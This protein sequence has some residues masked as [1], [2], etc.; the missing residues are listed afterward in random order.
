MPE[1]RNAV[2]RATAP[3]RRTTVARRSV[4][5][6]IV[7]GAQ[8]SGTTYLANLMA[9]Q[10]GFY[11]PPIKEIH[12]FNLHWAKGADWYASHFQLRSSGALQ[13]DASPSYMIHPAVPDRINEVCPE[14]KVVFVLRDPVS[15]A[16]SH[17]QH[18]KRAGWEPL[19]F[20]EALAAEDGRIS[21]DVGALE[22]DPN[23][24]G[25][26]YALYSYRTR[27]LYHRFLERFYDVLGADKILVLD[28]KKVFGGDAEEFALLGEFVGRPVPPEAGVGQRTNAG[29]Y[30]PEAGATSDATRAELRE[31][32]APHDAQLVALTGRRFS[33]MPPTD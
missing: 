33:W 29:T 4:A 3:L 14:A 13:V 11:S 26:D 8:K 5:D 17:Y 25:V 18:N 20:P 9:S 16:Y 27:G 19:E 6:V 7:C 32:F 28:S 2:F 30:A 21:A 10:P 12:F 15:R 23:T 22:K 31:Y 1:L 24:L